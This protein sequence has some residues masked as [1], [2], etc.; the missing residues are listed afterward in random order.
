M[1][2]YPALK[3]NKRTLRVSKLGDKDLRELGWLAPDNQQIIS[4]RH[5]ADTNRWQVILPYEMG[6]AYLPIVGSADTLRDAYRRAERARRIQRHEPDRLL[7][8]I[9]RQ[10]QRLRAERRARRALQRQYD[11]LA[12][13]HTHQTQRA[14]DTVRRLSN[15]LLR[16]SNA[17]DRV[18]AQLMGRSQL[19]QS[20]RDQ[21]DAARDQLMR[22]QA[23][24]SDILEL[25]LKKYTALQAAH[26][27]LQLA[28]NRL[29]RDV[30]YWQRKHNLP[31]SDDLKVVGSRPV[32]PLRSQSQPEPPVHEMTAIRI[33]AALLPPGVSLA[34]VIA[35]VE[36]LPAPEP[37]KT[38][39]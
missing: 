14:E 20:L 6:G 35:A 36:V 29:R 28:N 18:T 11:I 8:H 4:V 22:E 34:D 17:D 37:A 16:Q 38:G 25:H 15:E 3:A 32:Y 19:E 26:T 33:H 30:D 10:H 1:T 13:E 7:R 9:D 23:Q 27:D 2:L 5:H 21:L 39:A 24:A 31:T 12:A